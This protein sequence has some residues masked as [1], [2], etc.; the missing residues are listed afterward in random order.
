M[1]NILST[2]FDNNETYL[3]KHVAGINRTQA[4]PARKQVNSEE[5]IRNTFNDSIIVSGGSDEERSVLILGL[6]ITTA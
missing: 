4:F 2:L 1:L 6:T 5:F 3:S